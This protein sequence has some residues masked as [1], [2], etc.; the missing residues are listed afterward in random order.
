MN[1]DKPI[2]DFDKGFFMVYRPGGSPPKHIHELIDKAEA[3]AT[4]ICRSSGERVFILK[5]IS[6]VET[7]ESPVVLTRIEE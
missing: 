1:G 3:E 4:R 7:R 5:A 6:F 2:I